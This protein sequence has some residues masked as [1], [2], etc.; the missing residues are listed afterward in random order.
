MLRQYRSRRLSWCMRKLL[1]ILKLLGVAVLLVGSLV[2]LKMWNPFS[3]DDKIVALAGELA[4]RLCECKDMS[5]AT[6]VM[7]EAEAKLDGKE[8]SRNL[9]VGGD[10]HTQARDQ[11]MHMQRCY[12]LLSEG[13][14]FTFSKKDNR[15]T[16][17]NESVLSDF[18]I[19]LSL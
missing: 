7:E 16:Y 8:V 4:I 1:D 2:A 17:V 15:V 11:I 6:S 14:T 18:K 10:A 3:K 12:R 19:D 9:E 13:S 5:C